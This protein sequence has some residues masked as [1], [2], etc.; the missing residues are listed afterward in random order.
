MARNMLII[1]YY[2]G[3]TS[4]DYLANCLKKAREENA[5]DIIVMGGAEWSSEES[6]DQAETEVKKLLKMTGGSEGFH[7]QPMGGKLKIAL[8]ALLYSMRMAGVA[9][10]K[11]VICA[12]RSQLDRY[13]REAL[14]IKDLGLT[15]LS[16]HEYRSA[17]DG[18]EE[19][20]ER[21]PKRGLIKNFFS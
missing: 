16:T 20:Y 11:I 8:S 17:A 14:A 10:N 21:K 2:Y 4:N 15:K 13:Q 1:T 3:D 7:F 12:Q 9:I 6:H 19:K 5:R 18:K